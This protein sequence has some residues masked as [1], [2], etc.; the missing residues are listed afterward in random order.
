MK[1]RL[2]MTSSM[3]SSRTGWSLD[4]VA[5]T[6]ENWLGVSAH[7]VCLGF[8]PAW[9]YHSGRIMYMVAA[10][11]KASIPREQGRDYKAASDRASDVTQLH[12]HHI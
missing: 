9:Y 12:F 4:K 7:L 3:A 6:A 5:G 11:S 1:A 10:L 2:G 8:L